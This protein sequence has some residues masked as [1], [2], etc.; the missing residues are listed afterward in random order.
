MKNEYIKINYIDPKSKKRT[1]TTLP[2]PLFELWTAIIRQ[3][4]FSDRDAREDVPESKSLLIGLLE[5]GHNYWSKDSFK[6]EIYMMATG[7]INFPSISAGRNREK[8]EEVL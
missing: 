7:A 5:S 3:S 4:F 8:I 6:N 2:R 1:Q